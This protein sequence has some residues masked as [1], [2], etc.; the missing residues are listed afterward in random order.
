[1]TSDLPE[2]ARSF[3][4]AQDGRWCTSHMAGW[5]HA[6]E[7]QG[8]GEGAGPSPAALPER[9]ASPGHRHP[10][11]GL[12]QQ[13]TEPTQWV[14]EASRV[15]QAACHPG[16]PCRQASERGAR[17]CRGFV[18]LRKQ[19]LMLGVLLKS[20]VQPT[21]TRRS[22]STAGYRDPPGPG[23]TGGQQQATFAWADGATRSGT[24]PDP[25]HHLPSSPPG[26]AGRHRPCESRPV[27]E[28]VRV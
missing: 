14:T 9:A 13:P 26:A 21:N 1:M 3:P 19:P 5:G 28:P 25:P 12:R 18:V 17:V 11:R 6:P 7:G 2:A 15:T 16:P 24:P 27:A 23:H 22:P 20:S 10:R 4:T 8:T